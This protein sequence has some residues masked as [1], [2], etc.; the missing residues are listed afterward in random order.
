LG[1]KNVAILDGGIRE[2]VEKGFEVEKG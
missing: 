2:W 1:F